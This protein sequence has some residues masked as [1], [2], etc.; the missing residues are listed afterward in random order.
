M[1]IKCKWNYIVN[2]ICKGNEIS[3]NQIL[4]TFQFQ[5]FGCK[6]IVHKVQMIS[7]NNGIY[8]DYPSNFRNKMRIILVMTEPFNG[9]MNTVQLL[10][11]DDDDIFSLWSLR[12]TGELMVQ[13]MIR[14]LIL[15]YFYLNFTFTSNAMANNGRVKRKINEFN[16]YPQVHFSKYT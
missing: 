6:F 4:F 2:V 10:D 16:H 12:W 8:L 11:D 14:L 3:E 5:F 15:E 1:C 13:W 9:T 7:K